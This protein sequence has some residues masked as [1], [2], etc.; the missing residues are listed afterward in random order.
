MEPEPKSYS[1]QASRRETMKGIR[2]RSEQSDRVARMTLCVSTVNEALKGLTAPLHIH[3]LRLQTPE[4][5]TGQNQSH[6]MQR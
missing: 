5:P 3:L 2:T 1:T 6:V 4:P